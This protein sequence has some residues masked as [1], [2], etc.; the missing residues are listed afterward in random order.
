MSFVK[1]KQ[2]Y[3]TVRL[4]MAYGESYTHI[5]TLFLYKAYGR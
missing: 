4:F 2:A 5:A 1:N 3:R